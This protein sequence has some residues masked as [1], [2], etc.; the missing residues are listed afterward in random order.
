MRKKE[1]YWVFAVC[2]MM[3]SS[4]LGDTTSRITVG[5]QEAVYQVRPSRGLVLRDGRLIYSSSINSMRAD[6]GDCFMVE[7]SFDSSSPELQ[8]S[9]S[10]SVE[11]L[12]TPTEVPLWTSQGTIKSDTL[13]TDEQYI[14]ALGKR[15]AY[16]KGRLFLW[17]DIKEPISQLDSFVMQYDTVN[18]YTTEEGFRTYNLYLRAVRK[19]NIVANADSVKVSHTEAFDI[20][21]FFNKAVEME[22]AQGAK[23][24]TV[25]VNYVSKPN[26]DT[27]AV[28]WST[29]ELEYQLG[30]QTEE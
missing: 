12:G 22:T 15:S 24:F 10:L 2:L 26:K 20:E 8:N 28:E 4:C 13:L 23:A 16:I 27:T 1:L 7:Y 9:D 18:L 17:L 30:N 14:S 21:S 3:L 5:Q 6:A 25:G 11:L 19:S 29:L